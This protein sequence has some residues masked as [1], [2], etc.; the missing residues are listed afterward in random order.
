[1]ENPHKPKSHG[2][3]PGEESKEKVA[4]KAGKTGYPL[5]YLFPPALSALRSSLLSL[6]FHN[7]LSVNACCWW[8]F[9]FEL[10]TDMK[11]AELFIE[12]K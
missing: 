1:L 12:R 6:L 3:L 9:A 4:G 8:K 11:G 10:V 2:P 5:T 7:C